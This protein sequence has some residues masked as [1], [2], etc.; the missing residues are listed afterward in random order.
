MYLSSKLWRSALT[1]SALC[2]LTLQLQGCDGDD[3][4]LL[5]PENPNVNTGGSSAGMPGGMSNTVNPPPPTCYDR[6]LD[7]FQDASCNPNV[8][9]GGGDCDDTNNLVKPGR[10]ENC[11]NSVDN[12]CNGFLP[13]AD[14]ACAMGCP[15]ED[16]DGYQSAMCNSN[17]ANGADCDDRD[18]NTNPGA[19]E[20]CGNMRDDDCMGGDLP[21]LP[22]CTDNDSDG[23][24]QGAGCLGLDC[25]DT[26]ESINPRQSELCGDGVDQDCDGR[27]LTC[28]VNCVDN[29]RDGFGM[30]DNCLGP[31]CNDANP[32]I[33][34]GAVE[35]IGD[36]VDQDCDG[37][38][39]IA[40]QNCDDLDQ[41]GY[42]Q[43]SGCLGPDCDDSDPRINQGRRE[44]CGNGRDDDCQRGDLVCTTAQE[45]TCVDLDNDGHGE[46][47][48]L[49]SSLDCDDSNPEVNPFAEE[50]CNGIDDNCNGEID[51]CAGRNQV[52]GNNGQ[53]VGRVGSPCTQ[54]SECLS[55]L[56]LIC[57]PASRQCRVGPGNECV[58][59]EDCVASSECLD[60]SACGNGKR[61]YQRQGAS[62]DDACDCTGAFLCNDLN[63]ICVECSGYCDAGDSCTDG[64]FC[65]AAQTITEDSRVSFLSILADCYDSYRG[66][67]EPQGCA[68][69]D[70][71]S[72]I[73][74]DFGDLIPSHLDNNG[75][76]IPLLERA[77]EMEELVCDSDGVIATQLPAQY[78][79]L[80]ELFGCGLFDIW[81][82]FWERN[83]NVDETVC[84]YYAPRKSG[85][86]LPP[87]TRSEVVLVDRCDLS[88]IE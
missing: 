28:P 29:D 18:P 79:T 7:G 39:L 15:D 65:A 42:G 40:L 80:K 44:I 54:N 22:N 78:D 82:I 34:P 50:L 19:M 72:Y 13:A 66:S 26:N 48:C 9:F 88:V 76:P 61:C 31:D 59:D 21:C 73:Y 43:G 12:D 85:Y 11:A 58:E 17:R 27:D 52:C 51:E 83:I 75:D 5:P 32:N 45:G 46:G 8:N 33:N 74:D 57:D 67:P 53:C 25:N 69:V 10:M 2:A 87:F 86:G 64:G 14:P 60:L 71:D 62:C 84:V 30:G 24:G 38:D 47:A 3:Q 20:R 6:D 49:R 81:N 23:F 63:N 41:D 77:E 68:V 35:V 55:E 37:R 1:A 4:P 56:G 70:F 36:G 16:G